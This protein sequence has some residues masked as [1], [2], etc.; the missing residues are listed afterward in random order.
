MSRWPGNLIRKTPVTPAGPF[1]NGAAPG[2]WTLAE[3]AYWTK[4]GLWPVAGNAAPTM[5][6]FGAYDAVGFNNTISYVIIPTTGN[7]TDFGDLRLMLWTL[8]AI[9]STTRGI[10]AGGY[11]DSSGFSASSNID[12]VTFSSAGNSVNFGILTQSRQSIAT[13]SNQTR[14][15]FMGGGRDNPTAVCTIDYVTMASAGNAVTFGLLVVETNQGTG[16]DSPTR[17]VNF[18]GFRNATSA[19]YITIATTGNAISFGS[20]GSSRDR[21]SFSS[22][23]RGGAAGGFD[24][25]SYVSAIEYVTIA[26]TG[27]SVNFGNLTLARTQVVGGSSE[28]RGVFAGGSTGSFSNVIDYITIASTGNALDF[29]DLAS[30]RGLGG[31]TSNAHGGLN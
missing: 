26:T 25:A 10:I 7:D 16:F 5:M 14:G 20:C 6:I 19:R 29:G 22:S 27:N 13:C 18:A 21:A 12:F 30:T 2:V 17:G 8:A 1:Q 11:G 4:Q 9:G 24:G 28:I 31:G 3:A 23:T 15:V